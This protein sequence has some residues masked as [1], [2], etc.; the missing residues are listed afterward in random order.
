MALRRRGAAGAPEALGADFG[1]GGFL[2][3]FCEGILADREAPVI[4]KVVAGAIFYYVRIGVVGLLD[5]CI[6]LSE[7][8][9]FI[10]FFV[11]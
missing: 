6:V 1:P 2:L 4:A 3:D 7:L 5:V 8:L 11:F 9:V 10:L